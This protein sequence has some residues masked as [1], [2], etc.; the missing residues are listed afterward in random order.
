VTVGLRD[1]DESSRGRVENVKWIGAGAIILGS[2]AIGRG[3]SFAE[4]AAVLQ[5]AP[6]GVMTV[7]NPARI[8]Q[9]ETQSRTEKIF[10]RPVRFGLIA[11]GTQPRY[12]PRP[13]QRPLSKS[14]ALNDTA[15]IAGGLRKPTIR[16]NSSN[17]A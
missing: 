11:I 2:I 5:G 16:R 7:G 14:F 4:N 17:R 6:E 15:T 9:R 8:I 3:P 12:W 10:S 1:E 13:C